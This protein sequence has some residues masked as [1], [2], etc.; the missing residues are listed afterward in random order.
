[1]TL[2]SRDHAENPDQ[3]VGTTINSIPMKKL[4]SFYL[5]LLLFL[6]VGIT[7][8]SCKDDNDDDPMPFYSL[9]KDPLGQTYEEWIMDWWQYLMSHDCE[10]FSNASTETQTGPVHYLSGSVETY[11]RNVT[12]TSGQSILVPILN[13]LNDYPCPDTTF[14]PAP[15]QSLEDFMIEGARAA[16]DVA[17]DMELILDGKNYPITEENRIHTGLFYFTGN[18]DIANCIDPCVTGESQAAASDGYWYMIKPLS[19]GQHTLVLKGK[20]VFPNDTYVLDGTFNIT[21]N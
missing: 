19:K 6:A 12:I 5:Y 3:R 8:Y 16:M 10:T 18:P 9:D 11:S 7:T 17:A 15:G 4:N 20:L 13:Y 1:M 2:P 21:V 14:H